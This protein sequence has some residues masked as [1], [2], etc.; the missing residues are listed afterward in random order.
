ME[1]LESHLINEQF[2]NNS[3]IGFM[4]NED[5]MNPD[6]QKK[7][8]R[9]SKVRDGVYEIKFKIDRYKFDRAM[10]SEYIFYEIYC[11]F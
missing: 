8:R 2:V 10:R 9:I 5:M 6:L 7:L 1:R 4:P 3:F 11:F